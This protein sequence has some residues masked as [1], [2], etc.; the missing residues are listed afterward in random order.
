MDEIPFHSRNK[1]SFLCHSYCFFSNL[2]DHLTTLSSHETHRFASLCHSLPYL[3]LQPVLN[4]WEIKWSPFGSTC[5]SHKWEIGWKH[6]EWASSNLEWWDSLFERLI[7]RLSSLHWVLREW[8]G[9]ADY[10]PSPPCIA[11]TSIAGSW[12]LWKIHSLFQSWMD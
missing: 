2:K 1:E 4:L 3:I 10:S 7:Q 5:H 6:Q 12:I 8:K 9:W 11:S